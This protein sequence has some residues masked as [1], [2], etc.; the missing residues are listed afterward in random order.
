MSIEFR[1]LPENVSFSRRDHREFASNVTDVSDVQQKEHDS[2]IN[3]SE[4][5]I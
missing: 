2:Q 5:G 3:S 4:Q 1:P